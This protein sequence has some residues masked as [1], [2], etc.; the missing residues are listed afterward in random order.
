MIWKTSEPLSPPPTPAETKV[1]QSWAIRV[2]WTPVFTQ[3]LVI[4][5]A[6]QPVVRPTLFT[7]VADGEASARAWRSRR[8]V[9]VKLPVIVEA[10]IVRPAGLGDQAE[11]LVGAVDVRGT[12]GI[13]VAA[14]LALGTSR[15][16]SS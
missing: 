5:P 1:W 2:P 11:R 14:Q 7:V 6:V 16:C 15:Q 4:A 8:R 10:A 12:G 9:I 13:A 3:V